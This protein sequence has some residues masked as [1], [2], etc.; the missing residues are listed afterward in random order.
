MIYNSIP[1]NFVS[2]FEVVGCVCEVNGEIL[3]LHRNE[4]KSEGGKWG[5]PGGK[6]DPGETLTE[7]MVREMKEE[8]G[9]DMLSTDFRYIK[10]LYVKHPRHRFIYHLFFAALPIKPDVHLNPN[11][12][13]NF[14]WLTPKN[15]LTLNYV[16]DVDECLRIVYR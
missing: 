4:E 5:I 3:L 15:A 2:L 9:H 6:V 14:S 7:A 12:H 10:K 8:T 13:Q 11:E 1:E 16:T